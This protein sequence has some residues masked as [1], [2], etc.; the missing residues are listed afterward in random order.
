M[1][2][3]GTFNTGTDSAPCIATGIFIKELDR[4]IESIDDLF[5]FYKKVRGASEDSGYA[6]IQGLK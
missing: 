1:D 5:D 4:D 3:N 2:S 6:I